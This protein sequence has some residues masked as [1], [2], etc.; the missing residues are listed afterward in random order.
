MKAIPGRKVRDLID[1]FIQTKKGLPS[2]VKN[3]DA[4]AIF[5]AKGKIYILTKHRS[6]NFTKLYRLDY[7]DPLKKNPLTLIGSFD[8][9]GQITSADAS[10][11][12][13]RLVVLT[14]NGV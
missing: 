6:D 10:S 2:K 9:K 1:L 14:Y 8:I 3:F 5:W 11:D 7:M 12:G 4:E 13:N